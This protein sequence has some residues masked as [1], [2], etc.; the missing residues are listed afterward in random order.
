MLIQFFNVF[1]RFM[2]VFV[3]S[4]LFLVLV[5]QLGC[6]FSLLNLSRLLFFHSFFGYYVFLSF[7]TL[8]FFLKL[9]MCLIKSLENIFTH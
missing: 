9:F 8:C 5:I 3:C 6:L 4:S 7:V 2:V 1:V